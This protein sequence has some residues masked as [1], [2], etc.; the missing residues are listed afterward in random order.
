MTEA[1]I[2][3]LTDYPW[4]YE[5]GEE[6][7]DDVIRWKT[8]ISQPTTATKGLSCGILE[9]PPGSVMGPHYHAPQEI[10]YVI[11]GRGALQIDAEIKEV[12]AGSVVY[13]PQNMVH[14][15]KNIGDG[16]LTLVW[17]FPVD[18]YYDIEYKYDKTS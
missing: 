11:E 2:K 14:G 10:Y 9:M 8:L 13:I 12:T 17:V 15:V 5:V 7:R 16:L 1:I 4:T 3:T 6:G 18:S